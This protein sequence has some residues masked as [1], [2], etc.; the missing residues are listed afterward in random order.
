MKSYP[1]NVHFQIIKMHLIFTKKIL[2]YHVPLNCSILFNL[3]VYQRINSYFTVSQWLNKFIIYYYLFMFSN[4]YASSLL[5]V[6]ANLGLNF[7]MN[8]DKGQHS[9]LPLYQISR[10]V[11]VNFCHNY[12]PVIYLLIWYYVA[13]IWYFNC[14]ASEML[15]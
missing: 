7:T 4:A 1:L 15:T 11:Q 10:N 5:F 12:I 2:M 6:L 13:L 8:W 9:L 14:F 3:I